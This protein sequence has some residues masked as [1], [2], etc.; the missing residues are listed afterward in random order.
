MNGGGILN[1]VTVSLFVLH[2]YT[3]DL[4]QIQNSNLIM[5]QAGL[6]KESISTPCSN[7]VTAK[8]SATEHLA[9]EMIAFASLKL[10][11]RKKERKDCRRILRQELPRIELSALDN[12]LV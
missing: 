3:S 4:N 2:C 11:G 8:N 1:S 9:V 10:R 6:S 5:R 7:V 12:C